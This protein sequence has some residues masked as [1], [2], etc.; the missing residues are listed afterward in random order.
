M[1]RTS[2]PVAPRMVFLN[3]AFVREEAAVV[4]VFDRGFL[5]GDGLFETLR[6]F[7]GQPFR[8][9]QHFARLQSGTRFLNIRLPFNSETLRAFAGQ[10]ISR[11][12]MPDC[13]LRI[14]VS[15]GA[16]LRGYSTKGTNSPC[17]VMSLHAATAQVDKRPALWRL[18]TSSYRLPIGDPLARSK[19]SNKL[20]HILAKAEAEASGA[21]E[22]LMLNTAGWAIEGTSGNLFWVQ[23]G[24]LRTPPM[25][26]G[27]LPGVTRAVVFE[28]CRAQGLRIREGSI[29]PAQLA[30]TEG[31]FLSL[32]SIG[33][34]EAVALDGRRLKRSAL[35]R[36]L[37]SVYLQMLA[38]ECG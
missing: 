18:A 10:L 25:D 11:N 37:Q 8:W 20:P 15:R 4:S 30:H 1:S 33:I 12:R 21:D 38:R 9:E 26:S 3:G 27:I 28:L 34:V 32:S 2:V 7:N 16:G 22:S 5:Y 29:R 36:Q 23:G 14:N 24:E 17:V 13:V 31:V 35:V 6:V 19:T